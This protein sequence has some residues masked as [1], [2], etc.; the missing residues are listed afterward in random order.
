MRALVTGATGFIGSR[1]AATLD[2][3]VVLSRD[4]ARAKKS[5]GDVEAYAWSAEREP[6]PVAAFDGVDVVFHLAG[7]PVADGRW[8]PEK[9]RAI[10]DSRHLGTKNLVD[11]MKQAKSGAV[12]VSASAVGYYGNRGD[13]V[14]YEDA[15]PADDFLA[16]VCREWEAAAQ[17]AEAIGAR[18]A[19]ARIGIVLGRGGG[20]L[21]KML[22]LFKL[23]LGGR[24]ATG[25]QWMPWVHVDDVVGMLRL[26]ATRATLSG[27]FNAVSPNP[28]TN[29]EF[30]TALASAVHRPAILPAPEFGLRLM[31]GEFA[32]ILLASQRAMPGVMQAA[33]YEFLFP[34]PREALQDA[35]R[36]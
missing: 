21:E 32:E 24:L 10:R 34:Q 6:A 31:I 9:K 19:I 1:L 15:L 23:G 27:P 18:V 33:G 17:E 11:G 20:A 16:I 26:A 7:D 25:R 29:R 14:L 28:L 36:H 13:E 35:V 5:L 8:T 2:R 4:P 12:L 3:P 30:T 22:P